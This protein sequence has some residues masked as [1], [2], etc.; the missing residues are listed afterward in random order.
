MQ[1]KVLSVLPNPKTLAVAGGLGL[2]TLLP[3]TLKAQPNQDTFDTQKTLVVEN[4]KTGTE[5]LA[6]ALDNLS[7]LILI[8]TPLTVGAILGAAKLQEHFDEDAIAERMNKK[9]LKDYQR[10]ENNLNR[11]Y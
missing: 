6:E 4:Q 11:R 7:A 8:G 3:V 9:I 1:V 2:A 10:K 5:L